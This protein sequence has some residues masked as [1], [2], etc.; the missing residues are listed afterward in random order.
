MT[1]LGRTIRV[2][3]PDLDLGI[4]VGGRTPVG[5]LLALVPRR[6]ATSGT[7]AAVEP[8]VRFGFGSTPRRPVVT[9]LVTTIRRA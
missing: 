6:L 9:S 8:P 2:H 3:G 5:G 7:L 1:A 4:T